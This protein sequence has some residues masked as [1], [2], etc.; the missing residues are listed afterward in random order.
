MR[1][2]RPIDR[3]ELSDFIEQMFFN[4]NVNFLLKIL[5]RVYFLLIS[6]TGHQK[7]RSNVTQDF[8]KLTQINIFLQI[9]TC[10]NLTQF[11]HI[12]SGIE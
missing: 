10:F 4:I 11:T 8:L 6:E 9:R 7:L 12:R 5:V 3:I 1:K 2:T